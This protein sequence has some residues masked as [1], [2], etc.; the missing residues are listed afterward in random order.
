MFLFYCKYFVTLIYVEWISS[1]FPMSSFA[2]LFILLI[3]LFVL[4]LFLNS[5][6]KLILKL[7]LM[8]LLQVE[9]KKEK[10]HILNP[11]FFV[12]QDVLNQLERLEYLKDPP[13]F[14]KKHVKYV[15]SLAKVWDELKQFQDGNEHSPNTDQQ[16]S[17]PLDTQI[18]QKIQ[19]VIEEETH[20]LD[21]ALVENA[22]R[23]GY[24]FSMHTESSESSLS[25]TPPS[26]MPLHLFPNELPLP[27]DS[28]NQ[29]P[30]IN[31]LLVMSQVFIL[32]LLSNLHKFFFFF[33]YY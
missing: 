21:E 31:E 18:Q 17:A 6:S 26:N 29:K 32:N 28:S 3:I 25:K 27:S 4:F 8:D 33:I 12:F 10:F 24:I 30:E 14:T 1:N 22:Q 13:D 9:I 15:E 19:R 20:I 16:P 7:K 5:P 23:S 11:S 2:L